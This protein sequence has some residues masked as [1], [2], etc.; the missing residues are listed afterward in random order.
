[1][2]TSIK[3]LLLSAL[4]FPGAGHFLLKRYL[5][6]AVFAAAALGALA[7]SVGE[8]VTRARAVSDRILSGEVALQTDAIARAITQSAG[9]DQGLIRIATYALFVIWL[10][11]AI[12]AYRIGR[13]YHKIAPAAR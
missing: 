2:Q 9:A 3:G 8:A 1:M 4:V 11:A 13:G 6:G 10:A 7:V 12:D 5:R